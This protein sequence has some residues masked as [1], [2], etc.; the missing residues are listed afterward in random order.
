MAAYQ[1]EGSLV[2]HLRPCYARTEDEGRTLIQSALLSSAAIGPT[3][4]GTMRNA[5]TAEFASS[6]S[7]DGFGV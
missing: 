4:N 6:L 7:S 5:G 1:I 3:E 2:E